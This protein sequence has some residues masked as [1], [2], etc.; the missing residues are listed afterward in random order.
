MAKA[1]RGISRLPDVTGDRAPE[2]KFTTCPI[3]CFHLDVAEV[4]AEVRIAQGK[5]C[6]RVA[7]DPTSRFAF[8]RPV[9]K[10]ARTSA[11]AFLKTLAAAVPCKIRTIKDATVRRHHRDSH[12]QFEARLGSFLKRPLRR[13]APQDPKPSPLANRSADAGHPGPNGSPSIHDHHIPGPN[14]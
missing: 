11:P 1:S 5:L 6:L 9:R 10:T 4:G 3:G 2:R 8:A 13:S 14:S 12:S 7:I